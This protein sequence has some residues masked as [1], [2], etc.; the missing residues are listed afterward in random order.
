MGR[1]HTPRGYSLGRSPG[2]IE[3]EMI[4]EDTGQRVYVDRRVD[5][6]VPSPGTT[7]LFDADTGERYRLVGLGRVVPD[8]ESV[9]E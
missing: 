3:W 4:R 9:E 1:D 7:Y 8:P 5:A 2:K 6:E